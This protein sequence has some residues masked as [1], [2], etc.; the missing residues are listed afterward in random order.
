M[1]ALVILLLVLG[2]AYPFFAFGQ[3]SYNEGSRQSN[4]QQN[5]RLAADYIIKEVRYA[6][7]LRILPKVPAS[8]GTDKY[9][10]IY[11]N[12]IDGNNAIVHTKK[13]GTT[14][15]ILPNISEG[16]NF[17]LD[18]KISTNDDNMLNYTF[19]G[20]DTARQYQINSEL[21]ILN[22]IKIIDETDPSVDNDGIVL[23]YYLEPPLKSEITSV[24]L[25][26]L[27]HTHDE[28][29]HTVNVKVATRFIPN[30][31]T[32][33]SELL[34]V[35]ETG[36]IELGISDT[37]NL[38]DNGCEINLDVAQSV[39]FY[40]IKVTADVA[41]KVILPFYKG[42]VIRP[43]PPIITINETSVKID[44]ET[45][46]TIRIYNKN[47][48]EPLKDYTGA[49]LEYDGPSYTFYELVEGTEYYATQIING[50]E[51]LPSY[52]F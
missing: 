19:S 32:I 17:N 2:V 36:D 18:F 1:V 35:S 24:M 42:Y 33:T 49:I 7:E 6:K 28:S 38:I 40:V 48:G 44:S 9:N 26:P 27:E 13:D 51:S 15:N 37:T 50:V 4:V 46:S 23:C 22:T 47:T 45:G 43:A 34:R 10:Y 11:T 31:T 20:D 21:L 39:S 29:P 8:A 16:I 14:T 5:V 3:R 52:Q 30:G 41:G 12:T 25:N